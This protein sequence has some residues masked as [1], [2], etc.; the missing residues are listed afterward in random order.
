[1]ISAY[2]RFLAPRSA[3]VGGLLAAAAALSACGGTSEEIV[4]PKKDL[5]PASVTA[6]ST[7]T[8]R[9]AVGT[10][11]NAPIAV[12]VKNA[13]GEALDT[14]QVTFAVASG[15]GTLSNPTIRTNATGQAS[16]QWTLGSTS[17]L[18]TVTA[19]VGTLTPVTFRAVASAGNA[20]SMTRVAGD[21]QTGAVGTDVAIKP[22]VKLTDQFGNPVAGVSVAFSITAGGGLPTPLSV[23]TGADGVATLTNWR[24]GPTIGANTLVATAGSLTTSFAATATVGAAAT[25]ALTPNSIPEQLSGQTVQLSVRVADG[26]GNVIPSP[27][28]SYSSSSPNVASVTQTGLV[29]FA[30]AGTATITAA[31]GSASASV[32]VSVIGHPGMSASGKIDLATVPPGDVVFTKSNMLIAVPAQQKILVF[33]AEASAPIG[34]VTVTGGISSVVAP[35]RADGPAIA[36]SVGIP[37][38]LWF[39]N[40][41]S[42][43]I[44]D[45]LDISDLITNTV[46]TSD[47]R[48]AFVMLTGGAVAVVDV[49]TRSE[50]ARVPL[51]GGVQ[52]LV[53]APGDTLLYAVTNVGVLFKMDIRTNAVTQNPATMPNSD[54]V[55]GPDGLFYL[56]DGAIGI[57][58]V[59]DPVSLTVVRNISIAAGATTIAIAPDARQIWTTNNASLTVTSYTNQGNGFFVPSGSFSTGLSIATRVSINPRGTFAA[60]G[61][62]SGWVDILR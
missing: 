1:M 39:I 4:T 27:V 38:R 6:V 46:M 14:V 21:G 61:N 49:P 44:V 22:S 10:Q 12:I 15:N 34:T 36:T 11:T 13:A 24:L 47:G 59:F 32:T 33:D 9:G 17:G 43:A 30:G 16:T 55:M 60:I 40:P 48:R 35:T 20:T 25:V 50:V 51:G 29:T 31:V 7:D 41:A 8:L 57:V 5:V 42:A 2:H 18:Q 53:V 52:K 23:T 26:F 19:T 62:L 3:L 37:S 45:S 54:F 56:L 28:V 58:R